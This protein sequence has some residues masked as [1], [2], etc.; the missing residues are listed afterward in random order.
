VCRYTD[1]QKPRVLVS[2]AAVGLFMA[3]AWPLI[4]YHAGWWG[5]V[6]YW[7][8]PWLGY[9]FWMSEFLEVSAM[10][11]Q[12]LLHVGAIVTTAWAV[13]WPPCPGQHVPVQPPIRQ[14]D[15]KCFAT[16]RHP[17]PR[18]IHCGPPHRPAHTLQARG[19]VECGQGA[20]VRHRALRLSAGEGCFGRGIA[21]LPG[22]ACNW[23]CMHF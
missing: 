23:Q 2:L 3:V 5:L 8:M 20:I 6:K 10:L 12:P 15:K 9:H 13:R 7:L 17:H 1:Q 14:H 4:V 11:M 19:R 21:H 22:N 18:H 16:H